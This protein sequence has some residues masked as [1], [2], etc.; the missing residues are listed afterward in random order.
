VV[1]HWPRHDG[2]YAGSESVV[3]EIAADVLPT[4][5]H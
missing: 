2:V 3:E 4:L 5:G 1:A